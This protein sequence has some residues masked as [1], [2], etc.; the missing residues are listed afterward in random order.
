M[1][2][3]GIRLTVL[4]GATLPVPLPKALTESIASVEVTHSDEARSGF[5]IVFQV[6]RDRTNYLDFPHLQNN[7][8]KPFARVI[9]MV[10]L[11][12]IPQVI[13]DGIVTNQ[14][15][16]PSNDPG[17]ST[18]TITGEDVSVMM[19]RE[20]KNV[21]HPAQPEN[22]IATKI[23]GQYAQ[24][25]LIPQVI[26]PP[27][28]DAPPPTERIPT[29]QVTD[30]SYLQD[31]ARRYNYVFYV[32][33]GPLPGSN[34]AY[35][36][37]LIRQGV[38]QPALS[39]N[40]G[41]HSNIESLD[42][43]NDALSATAV[44]GQVQDRLT[45]LTLPVVSLASLLPALSGNPPDLSSLLTVGRQTFRANGQNVVQAY[46]QAQAQADASTRDVVT[47]EGEL[48]AL[49][50]GGVLQ[51]RSLVGLRGVGLSYSGNYYVKKVTHAIT[52]ETYKQRF[53][54]ARE[55]NGAAA[56]LVRP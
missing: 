43:Q 24:Y 55:G 27:S 1:T 7:Q 16:S 32:S 18:L 35:W 34:T 12:L 21:E 56:S 39:Y 15:L 30:L 50:Y 26:P 22:I 28:L 2:L 33:P 40:L 9:L 17:G 41:S 49:R 52:N 53:T 54:L 19:D 11:G 14:Q 37:P 6:G 38:P 48:N 25:G 8:L 10:T 5:Q 42:F 47:A 3:L 23:I 46:A 31:L 20:E 51:A 4:A 13:M 45:N 44:T 36:G 29:Q